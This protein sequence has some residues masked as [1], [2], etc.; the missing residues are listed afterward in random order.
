MNLITTIDEVNKTLDF[1]NI[2]KVD[3]KGCDWNILKGELNVLRIIYCVIV[4][5]NI[6]N[7]KKILSSVDFNISTLK[8]SGYLLA[9]NKLLKRIVIQFEDC[10]IRLWR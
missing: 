5:Q 2:I 1:V 3:T 6:S 7:M 10:D 9:T 8:P 4:E